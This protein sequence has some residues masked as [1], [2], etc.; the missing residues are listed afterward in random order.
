MKSDGSIFPGTLSINAPQSRAQIAQ[1]AAGMILQGPWNIPQWQREN[2]DFKFGVASQPI[3]NSGTPTPLGHGPG[4]SNSL[5]VYA[6]SPYKQIAADIFHYVGTLEG[7]T[8]WGTIS[9]GGDSPIF[10]QA[11]KLAQLSPRAKKAEELF[12]Q[13]MRLHPDP[14]VRNEDAGQVYLEL[15]PLKPNFG[16]MVQGIYSGQLREPRAAM[17]DLQDR[18][19]K[20]LERAIKVVADKGAKV[21]RDDWK[22][23]NWDPTKDYTQEFYDALRR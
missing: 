7:Q 3:P 15:K 19:E 14:R 21:S 13:Q 16:E 8:A 20:E 11:N 22:F 2:P 4:G 1:G 9:D 12:E 17:Q 23:A 10:P 18:A 5:W 6:K